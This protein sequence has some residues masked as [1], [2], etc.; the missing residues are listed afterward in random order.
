MSPA[1]LCVTCL[2]MLASNEPPMNYCAQCPQNFSCDRNGQVVS[3]YSD[4]GNNTVTPL[5]PCPD[6]FNTLWLNVSGIKEYNYTFKS[7]IPDV[8]E[9]LWVRW[10][11]HS[12]WP[13]NPNPTQVCFIIINNFS[14][15]TFNI[16]YRCT[17]WKELQIENVSP[18]SDSATLGKTLLVLIE[19]VHHTYFQVKFVL[20]WSQ[21]QQGRIK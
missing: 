11:A 19:I 2:S 4:S 20:E 14:V 18:Y 5:D 7:N 1:G 3:S 13:L 9:F 6:T 12:H 16:E 10:D 21:H 17:E 8:L 15:N